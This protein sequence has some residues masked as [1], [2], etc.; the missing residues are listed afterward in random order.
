MVY[1]H[2]DLCCVYTETNTDTDKLAQN[3]VKVCVGI[4]PHDTSTEFYTALFYWVLYWSRCRTV[5]IHHYYP[6]QRSWG[7]VIFSQASVIL[8]TGGSAP[9]GV[10]SGGSLVLGG[11]AWW[12]PLPRT[13]TAAGGTHPTGMHSCFKYISSI[14]DRYPHCK[15]VRRIPFSSNFSLVEWMCPFTAGNWMTNFV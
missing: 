6:P 14:F 9:G 4:C 2:F 1:F 12:R 15:I 7:K 8:L 3:S 10:S 11:Y 5:W 13:A